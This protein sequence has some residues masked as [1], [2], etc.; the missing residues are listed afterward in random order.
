MLTLQNHLLKTSS[1]AVQYWQTKGDLML[2][3]CMGNRV[4]VMRLGEL[5][6]TPPTLQFIS[7]AYPSFAFCCC[8]WIS[9][10]E[11]PIAL[12]ASKPNVELASG[13]E[14]TVGGSPAD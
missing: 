11:A 12:N 14:A 13:I 9:I 10:E 7:N 4:Q 5:T 8:F 1:Y 3:G 6:K 2:I